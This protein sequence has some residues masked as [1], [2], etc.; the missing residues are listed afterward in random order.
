[1][2]E[3]SATVVVTE[4][5]ELTVIF[6]AEKMPNEAE[7]LEL[8]KAQEFTDILDEDTLEFLSVESIE[9]NEQEE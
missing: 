2:K 3:F 7:M 4:K 5:R 6:E 1:M 9:E 8:L